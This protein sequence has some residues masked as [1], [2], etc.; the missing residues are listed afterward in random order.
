MIPVLSLFC[1]VSII[2]CNPETEQQ[3]E[4]PVAKMVQKKEESTSSVTAQEVEFLSAEES[5]E[6]E[7][8]DIHGGQR[9]EKIAE[10]GFPTGQET[11]EG[12]ACDAI[13][14]FGNCDHE[15][16]LS[17]LVRPIYGDGDQNQE[18]EK[19]KNFKVEEAKKYAQ[20]SDR[21][22]VRLVK[23]FKSRS[24]STNGPVSAAFAL[25]D[26]QD[27][28]FVDMHVQIGENVHQMRYQMLLDQDDKWYFNPRPDLSSPLVSM[29]LNE[30]EDSTEEW[31]LKTE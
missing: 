22:K 19:F 29:G 30:E 25:L 23:V 7:H 17:L 3:A 20:R 26:F 13:R 4:S 16:W 24:F 8:S 28:Q 2:S 5:K 9:K 6:K 18:Y 14:A 15:A 10:D 21:P 1:S 27:N 12:A 31:K 11:P